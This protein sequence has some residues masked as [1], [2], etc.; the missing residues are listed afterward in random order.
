MKLLDGENDYV[1]Q[2]VCL[3]ICESI[4]ETNINAR[5]V[6]YMHK[7]KSAHV[8]THIYMLNIKKYYMVTD[9]MFLFL[10]PSIFTPAMLKGYLRTC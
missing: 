8:H 7:Y 4:Q 6:H 3:Q 1:T 9:F 10:H 5:Y 2:F